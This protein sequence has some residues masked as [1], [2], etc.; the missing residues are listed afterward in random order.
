MCV[1]VVCVYV[2]GLWRLSIT[3]GRNIPRP[4]PDFL[5]SC[6]IKSGSGLGTRLVKGRCMCNVEVQVWALWRM[7]NVEDVQCGGAGVGIVEDVQCG[8]CAMWRCRCGHCGGCAMWRMCN[9][10]VQVWA[11]WRMCNV[12][13][14]QCGGAGMQILSSNK[15]CIWSKALIN[16]TSYHS[17]D[18]VD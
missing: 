13:D 18:V 16:Y 8:G 10:E 6:E 1:C 7:C 4:L 11:L 9:V 15:M 17:L 3:K 5:H 12:E 14:V 2:C